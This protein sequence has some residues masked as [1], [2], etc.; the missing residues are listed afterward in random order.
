MKS[1][2]LCA[3]ARRHPRKGSRR[4]YVSVSLPMSDVSSRPPFVLTTAW[5]FS[6]FPYL[7]YN[8]LERCGQIAANIP[9]YICSS[10][11]SDILH[12]AF[13]LL[14]HAIFHTHTHH[15]HAHEASSS[16]AADGVGHFPGQW[17]GCYWYENPP[18]FFF[19][20]RI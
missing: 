3:L 9:P 4:D 10:R 5:T 15:T 14:R 20:T 8:S 16:K 11:K 13:P 18:M 6:K 2:R 7:C 1:K 12:H 17:Y 19:L